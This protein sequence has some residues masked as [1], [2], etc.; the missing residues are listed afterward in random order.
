MRPTA[1]TFRLNSEPESRGQSER[2]SAAAY[3]ARVFMR[4]L[5]VRPLRNATQIIL[6]WNSAVF[7]ESKPPNYC[8]CIGGVPFTRRVHHT[9]GVSGV[10]L[11]LRACQGVC[12]A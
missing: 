9:N 10:A 12:E 2:P 5:L 7:N 3:W 1:E 11:P 8:V 4:P 6:L